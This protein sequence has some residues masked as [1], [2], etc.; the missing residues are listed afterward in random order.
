MAE[1]EENC[2]DADIFTNFLHTKIELSP[3]FFGKAGK[4]KVKQIN[5]LTDELCKTGE[6]SRRGE[7]KQSKDG[8][9]VGQGSSF[10]MSDVS[11]ESLKSKKT[12]KR[13]RTTSEAAV[14][15]PSSSTIYSR[16]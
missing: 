15:Y 6:T 2:Y 4:H 9:P 1:D 11:N 3:D 7:R 5:E 14:D 8:T 16:T 10:D 12:R 13:K